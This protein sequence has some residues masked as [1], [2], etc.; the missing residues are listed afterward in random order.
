V[1]RAAALLGVAASVY[2]LAAWTVAPGFYDC[3]AQSPVY[4]WVCP[5]PGQVVGNL[6]AQAG[7]VTILVANGVSDVSSAATSDGQLLIGLL[8]GVFD[9]AGKSTISVDITPVSPCPNP[10][11]LHFATNAYLVSASA[12]L[13]KNVNLV[14]EYSGLVPAPSD[15][16]FA[17][18][19]DGPWTSIGAAATAQPYTIDTTIKKFGY[20]AAGYPSNAISAGGASQLLPIAVA[21]LILGVLIAG[22]PLAVMRRRRAVVDGDEMDDSDETNDY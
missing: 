9:A 8:P 16:Y 15:V 13:V 17:S 20:F 21:V 18:N 7:S 2:V 10:P 14:L 3:C 6:P 12:T 5:P 4:N 11:G 19:P 22:V 1:K